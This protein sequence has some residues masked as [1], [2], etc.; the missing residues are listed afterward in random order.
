MHAETFAC[1]QEALRLREGG[2]AS[3]VVAVTVGGKSS[4]VRPRCLFSR[5]CRSPFITHVSHFITV[6]CGRLMT[7]HRPYQQG[8]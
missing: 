6:I 1:M 3:E 5:G 8:Q 4:E 7:G 2:H